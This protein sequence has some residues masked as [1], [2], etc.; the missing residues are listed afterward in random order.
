[1]ERHVIEPIEIDSPLA[2]LV[3]F[4]QGE[5]RRLPYAGP[6]SFPFVDQRSEGGGPYESTEKRTRFG[7]KAVGYEVAEFVEVVERGAVSWTTEETVVSTYG[8]EGGESIRLS[9]FQQRLTLETEGPPDRTSARVGRF[10][11]RFSRAP[12][13]ELVERWALEARQA[14]SRQAWNVARP[15]AEAVLA[16]DPDQ[17]DALLALGIAQGAEGDGEG[18][19]RSL[20]RLLERVPGHVDALYNLGNLHAERGDW[21][22][23]AEHY[24]RALENDPKNHPAAHRLGTALEQ[25]GRPAEALAAHRR[26]VATSPNPG[27]TWGY[28]GLDFTAASQAAVAR[29]EGGGG[30]GAPASSLRRHRPQAPEA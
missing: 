11:R 14:L 29:L 6:A 13:A 22:R 26:A 8:L 1:M 18:A 15:R 5:L 30:S 25:L 4:V 9:F 16:H 2:K 17:P 7:S 21:L 28:S 23:A 19:E 12:S 24:A 27:G 20:S 3:E 10:E